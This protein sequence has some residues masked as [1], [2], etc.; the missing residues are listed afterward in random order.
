[1]ADSHQHYLRQRTL[2]VYTTTPGH[3]PTSVSNISS[4][5]ATTQ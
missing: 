5:T 3:R 4:V 1:M 2:L